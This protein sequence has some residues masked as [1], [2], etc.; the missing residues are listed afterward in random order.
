MRWSLW[1]TYVAV[2]AISARPR[3]RAAAT[4]PRFGGALARLE[5]SDR[6]ANLLMR[7]AV[8]RTPTVGIALDLI[9][10]APVLGAGGRRFE[11][12]PTNKINH[13]T[14]VRTSAWD[15]TW[16]EIKPDKRARVLAVA[17][18][19]RACFFSYSGTSP[20]GARSPSSRSRGDRRQ[21]TGSYTIFTQIA[22]ETMDLPVDRVTGGSGR[23]M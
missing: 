8:N 11:S 7:R 13:L 21:G 3:M 1:L 20:I 4:P 22:A 18:H 15:E 5:H 14:K 19:S 2:C 10:L 16:D 17:R 6:G 12:A 9:G 23:L